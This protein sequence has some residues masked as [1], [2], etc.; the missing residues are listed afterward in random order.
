MYEVEAK[1]WVKNQTE[2]ESLK[3]K[4][5]QSTVFL[6]KEQKEDTYFTHPDSKQTIF[7]LRKTN[8]N[9]L[10]VTIKDK[11]IKNGVEETKEESFFVSDEETF[12][13]FC[14]KINLNIL[15]KKQKES[16]VYEKKGLKIELNTINNLGNF[17]EIEKI[18]NKE[19]ELTQANH[20]IIEMFGFLGYQPK[21][22]EP[23]PYYQL[24]T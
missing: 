22:F 24:F 10:E 19:E 1:V 15:L 9:K 18:V 5:E 3:K 2:W 4:I 16:L 21:D 6:Y 8:L 11:K 17:L 7:R 12:L 20:E 13:S 23:K 14:K